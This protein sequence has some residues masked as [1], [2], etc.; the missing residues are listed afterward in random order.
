MREVEDVLDYYSLARYAH[1]PPKLLQIKLTC[2]MTSFLRLSKPKK[3]ATLFITQ[4]LITNLA[5]SEA[6]GLIAVHVL[7]C[8]VGRFPF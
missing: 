6:R 1:S 4:L 3:V 7:I 2:S 8:A 5:D